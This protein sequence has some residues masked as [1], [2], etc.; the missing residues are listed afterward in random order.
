MFRLFTN[1]SRYRYLLK[2]FV[3]GDLKVK[4]R[5]SVAGY[6]WTLLEPMALVAT[7]YFIFVVI[8]RRGD[9]TYPLVVLL[10]VLPYNLFSSIVNG[11]ANSLVANAS[12]IRRVY[13]PRELFLIA[14]LGSNLV[15]F[16][17]SLLVVIPFLFYYGV[18][19]TISLLFLLPAIILIVLFASGI[20]LI[21]S[22]INVLYRDVGYLLSVAL[23]LVFY[24]SPVIYSA[25]MVPESLRDLYFLNP[26]AVFLSLIRAAILNEPLI[27][28]TGHIAGAV[29]ASFVVLFGGALFFARWEGRVVKHL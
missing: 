28:T 1:A 17:S 3:L 7:Y 22:C 4:Y 26:L 11:G 20:A 29:I 14:L 13:L 16:F 21:A 9:H 10:G 12:L 2:N 5:G 24:G 15:V 23:R 18:T 6:L 8:A 25:H 19:P 27:C